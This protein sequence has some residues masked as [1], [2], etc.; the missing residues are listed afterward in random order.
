MGIFDFL[1]NKK[2][3]KGSL[4]NQDDLL[5]KVEVAPGISMLSK[6]CGRTLYVPP[7]AN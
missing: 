4:N 2:D 5:S 6:G 3:N 7:G 1:F